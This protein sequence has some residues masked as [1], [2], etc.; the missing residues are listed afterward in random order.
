VGGKYPNIWH[1]R[2]LENPR[3]ISAG[4]NMPNFQW[5]LTDTLDLSVMPKRIG[6][7]RILG[8]P[9]PEMTG[10]QVIASARA[11]AAQ[12]ADDL[13]VAG[14]NVSPDKE[15]IAVIAYLQKLGKYEPVKQKV[16]EHGS[17]LAD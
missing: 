14:A 15:V 5:L 12:I 8:V 6:V 7:Q 16:A 2:H 10:E 4:S 17:R 9:Y 3:S 11:Q 1:L 13:R